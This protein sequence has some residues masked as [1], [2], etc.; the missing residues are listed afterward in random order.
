MSHYLIRIGQGSKYTEEARKEGFVAI[1]W[2]DVPDL[3]DIHSKEE[4]AD[5]V[6]KSDAKASTSAQVGQL[7]RFSHEIQNGDTILS[8]LGGGE[9]IFGEVGDYYFEE[10]PKGNCPFKHKRH[11]KWNDK[12]LLKEDMS[13]NLSY[14][15]GGLLT[16]FSLN[17]YSKEL[18]DLISGNISS[19]PA[20]R[21]LGIR[22]AIIEKLFE[23]DGKEFEE[24]IR[25][26]LEI[27]GFEASTTQYVGDKGVDVNGILNA[28]GI[29][30]II[31]KI[32]V[33]RVRG[34]IGNKDV[35]A[36][37]GT[38]IQGEHAC[39]V[40]L[41]GF[42]SQ[43]EEEANSPGK[44]QIK[45]IDGYD[46]ASIILKHFDD[47]DEEYKILFNIKKKKDIDIEDQF[48]LDLEETPEEEILVAEN[49]KQFEFDTVVC[50]AKEEGFNR[51]FIGENSWYA[52]RLNKNVIPFIKYIAIYQVAPIS[53]ITY[54]GEIEKIEPYESTG[55]YIVYLKSQAK[56]LDNPI[57]LGENTNL[58]PQGPRYAKFSKLEISK[59]LDELFN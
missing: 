50:A 35:L 18:E 3:K 34:T 30:D 59:T 52:I 44:V 32:Q 17:K 19:T 31:L 42:T 16:V 48:E 58:K 10:N 47:I 38:L 8:P 24:F 22:D 12:I 56:R 6:S 15:L 2:N 45:L 23:L 49:N 25:H 28:E 5:L 14:G 21:P 20:D 26:V 41:S 53:A 7:W 51:V 1:G 46:L 39:L 9:Y 40:S 36:L 37:R 11:I 13:A 29:A 27:L 54:Y 57:T 55:K 33:K 43:A 4:I